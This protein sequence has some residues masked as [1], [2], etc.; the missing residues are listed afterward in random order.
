MEG[1]QGPSL[2]REVQEG[3]ALLVGFGAK[4]GNIGRKRRGPV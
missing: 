3:G 4:P 1:F 2:W